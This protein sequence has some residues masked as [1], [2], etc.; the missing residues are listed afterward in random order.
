MGGLKQ[1]KRV[2]LLEEILNKPYCLRMT[3]FADADNERECRELVKNIRCMK[4]YLSQAERQGDKPIGVLSELNIKSSFAG[5]RGLDGLEQIDS[6]E[7]SDEEEEGDVFDVVKVQEAE[8]DKIFDLA[9]SRKDGE[10]KE[11]KKQVDIEDAVTAQP[12]EAK[13]IAPANNIEEEKK[14]EKLIDQD[15]TPAGVPE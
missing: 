4:A 13:L 15:Q 8:N 3:Y 6:E 1:T 14:E 5:L 10:G 9:L 7:L 11:E 2:Y 12:D